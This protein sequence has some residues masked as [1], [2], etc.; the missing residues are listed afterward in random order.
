MIICY[1]YVDFL[2]LAEV[3][4]MTAAI[5]SLQFNSPSWKLE[6]I[7][8]SQEGLFSRD[9]LPALQIHEPFLSD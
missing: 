3:R 6:A 5:Q 9:F 2:S 1:P 8:V 4:N 7:E